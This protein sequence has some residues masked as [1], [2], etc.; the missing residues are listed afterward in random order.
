MGEGRGEYSDKRPYLPEEKV[1]VKKN[2]DVA[3][4]LITQIDKELAVG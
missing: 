3:V 2:D 1:L 4:H